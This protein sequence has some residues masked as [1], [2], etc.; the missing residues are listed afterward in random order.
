MMKQIIEESP[1][2]YALYERTGHE[3]R[4]EAGGLAHKH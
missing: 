4:I 3:S 2:V 1:Y